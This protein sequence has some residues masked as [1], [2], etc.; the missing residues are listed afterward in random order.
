MTCTSFSYNNF[1]FCPCLADTPAVLYPFQLDHL[2]PVDQEYLVLSLDSPALTFN[3]VE[4]TCKKAEL[5]V[6]NKQVYLSCVQSKV[7]EIEL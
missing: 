3:Y 1:V 7:Q 2:A 4:G 5:Q 6:R